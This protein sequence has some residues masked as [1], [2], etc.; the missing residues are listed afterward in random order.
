MGWKNGYKFFVVIAAAV[1]I[2]T[3]LL[4]AFSTREVTHQG[5]AVVVKDF[6]NVKLVDNDSPPSV[7][8]DISHMHGDSVES[9][10]SKVYTAS[11]I[12]GLYSVAPE[13][14]GEL[15]FDISDQL[16]AAEVFCNAMPGLAEQGR[17][18]FVEFSQA[19]GKKADLSEEIIHSGVYLDQL[20]LRFCSDGVDVESPFFHQADWLTTVSDELKLGE[21]TVAIEDN[22]ETDDE[23]N[24]ARENLVAFVA[25][26][27]SP[28]AFLEA[29]S[30][31]VSDSSVGRGWRP[32]GYTA[33]PPDFGLD[34]HKVGTLGAELAYCRLAP[35]ACRGDGINV[36]RRCLPANCRP[37]ESLTEFLQRTHSPDVVAAAESYAAALLRLRQAGGG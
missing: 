36:V 23:V 28:A 1:V 35:V 32:P 21:L 10:I 2:A 9:K 26:T 34:N 31:L 15:L 4:G 17:N 7:R 13:I 27:E 18:S 5:G 22:F 8:K 20:R 3:Y 19:L 33:R 30:I 16:N 11:S 14:E 24:S 25:T 6:E 37:N 29:V 12:F